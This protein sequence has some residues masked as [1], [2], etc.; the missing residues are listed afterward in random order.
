MQMAVGL[1]GDE[2]REVVFVTG[3]KNP[4][5]VVIAYD[6]ATGV[7]IWQADP[8]FLP[9]V[10]SLSF[11]LVCSTDLGSSLQVYWSQAEQVLVTADGY[12][13]T[14]ANDT[15]RKSGEGG[16]VLLALNASTGAFVSSFYH[17]DLTAGTPLVMDAEMNIYCGSYPTWAIATRRSAV[18]L[19]FGNI[20]CLKLSA[21]TD[22]P[23]LT[24]A[25]VSAFAQ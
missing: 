14:Y 10:T 21:S 6:A 24:L 2:E 16:R 5:A 4:P 18:K 17:P 25:Q 22:L 1:S 15:L 13:F 7:L 9:I 23:V 20:T 8:R 3:T 11:H 12:L 19:R